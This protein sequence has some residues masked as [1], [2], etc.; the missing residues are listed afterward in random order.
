M[1]A[2]DI[3]RLLELLDPACVITQDPALP[4]G[5]RASRHDGF[6]V[7]PALSPVPSTRRDH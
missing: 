3:Q 4:W 7:L 2:R 1:A 6:A 5:G